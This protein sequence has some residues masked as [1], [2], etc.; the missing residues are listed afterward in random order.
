[1]NKKILSLDFDGVCHK[2]LSP[3]VDEMTIPDGH[4]EGLFP[5]LLKTDKDFTIQV[6][7]TR[8]A[9]AGGRLAMAAW[10]QRQAREYSEAHSL[11]ANE[12]TRLLDV[13]DRVQFPS[14]KP[15][16]FVG[17]DDR[18]FTFEGQWPAPEVLL[19]WKP[20]NK[21]TSG[22]VNVSLSMDRDTYYLFKELL[23]EKA[24]YTGDSM[25]LSM[26]SRR[27]LEAFNRLFDQIRDR[28]FPNV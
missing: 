12:E 27:D 16:A 1:M 13:V 21:R 5:F 23:R 20:W 18:I 8:S 10:F 3:W 24:H 19:G 22:K 26:S 15:K 2:Y 4:V 17:L 6:Y 25:S 28:E 14:S 11:T 7:S 9:T